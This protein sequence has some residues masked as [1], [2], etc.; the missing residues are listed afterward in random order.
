MSMT[1][2]LFE[3]LK[4]AQEELLINQVSNEISSEPIDEV[5]SRIQNI[6]VEENEQVNILNDCI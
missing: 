4:E 5:T 6:E 2:T 1:F 3:W